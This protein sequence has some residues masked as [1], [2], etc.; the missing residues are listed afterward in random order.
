MYTSAA[1]VHP[2]FWDCNIFLFKVLLVVYTTAV[3]DTG[4]E[5]VVESSR[6]HADY[7]YPHNYHCGTDIYRVKKEFNVGAG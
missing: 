7:C 1:K 4:D 2:F 3:K 5:R 6:D